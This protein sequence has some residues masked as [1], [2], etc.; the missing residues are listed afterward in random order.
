MYMAFEN[1]KLL[2]KY[3][4][5]QVPIKLQQTVYEFAKVVSHFVEINLDDKTISIF[6]KKNLCET[7]PSEGLLASMVIVRVRNCSPL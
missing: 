4:Y 1:T 2:M 3:V 6:K 5:V 7:H